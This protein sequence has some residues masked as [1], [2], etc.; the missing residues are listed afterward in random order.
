MARILKNNIQFFKRDMKCE[1]LS[2]CKGCISRSQ[3]YYIVCGIV[4]CVVLHCVWRC[5]V[6]GIVMC[7]LLYCAWYCTLLFREDVRMYYR[8]LVLY[9]FNM[10]SR[11]LV[12]C[13]Q[14]GTVS[15]MVKD[16]HFITRRLNYS[17]SIPILVK[18]LSGIFSR[19]L[20]SSAPMA[21]NMS[22]SASHTR[23]DVVH[24]GSLWQMA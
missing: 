2:C 9:T 22:Q 10:K 13:G 17:H 5:I 12:T 18:P 20:I 7:V 15:R 6:Y 24:G 11:Q 8:V 23:K 3:L 21:L 1:S 14:I 4:M 16:E 19:Y